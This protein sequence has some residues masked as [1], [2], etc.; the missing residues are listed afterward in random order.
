M[1]F[2]SYLDGRR[3]GVVEHVVFSASGQA[4]VAVTAA[5]SLAAVLLRGDLSSIDRGA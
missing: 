5:I 3:P 4:V 2:R 1:L